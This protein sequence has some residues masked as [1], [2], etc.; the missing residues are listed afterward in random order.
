MRDGGYDLEFVAFAAGARVRLRRVAYAMCGDW[1]HAEDIVQAALVKVYLAWARV[2]ADLGAWSYARRAVVNVAI[3]SSRR[4]WRREDV[5]DDL[6]DRAVAEPGG[7]DDALLEA[8]SALPARQRAVV[9]P[10]YVEGLDIETVA[11]LLGVSSGT[12][13]SQAARGLDAMRRRL[14]ATPATDH[15]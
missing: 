13:K 9:V 15:R 7:L 3:D 2:E 8:L 6:P 5:S 1:H 11:E 10:R 14:S 12:V 4:P